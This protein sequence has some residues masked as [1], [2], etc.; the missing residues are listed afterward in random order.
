MR[1][2]HTL[3]T[4]I[5]EK[6]ALL[7]L[8]LSCCSSSQP[9][10]YTDLP[11]LLLQ[12]WK[13]GT[14]PKIWKQAASGCFCFAQQSNYTLLLICLGFW[15]SWLVRLMHYMHLSADPS[16]CFRSSIFQN[17]FAKTWNICTTLHEGSPNSA[18]CLTEMSANADWANNASF[19]H[20][21][22]Y[23][24]LNCSFLLH[25]LWGIPSIF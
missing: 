6:Q 10:I 21:C 14:P 24:V 12:Q 16:T 23:S 7:C 19:V 2:S 1:N 17:K 20:R 22:G 4:V 13:G 5:L 25:K 18:R 15:I 8:A 9:P 3:F 11:L